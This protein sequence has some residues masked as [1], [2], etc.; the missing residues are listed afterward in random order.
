MSNNEFF[1]TEITL[2]KHQREWVLKVY[3]LMCQLDTGPVPNM[4]GEPERKTAVRLIPQTDLGIGFDCHED[5]PHIVFRSPSDKYGYDKVNTY[6]LTRFIQAIYTEF[7]LDTCTVFSIPSI[8]EDHLGCVSYFITREGILEHSSHN[9]EMERYRDWLAKRTREIVH[10][11]FGRLRD[12]LTNFGSRLVRFK[13]PKCGNDEFSRAMLTHDYVEATGYVTNNGDFN[14]EE[15]GK[16]TCGETLYANN[17]VRCE[18]CHA[19]YRTPSL[20]PL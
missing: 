10:R 1:Y 6:A 13:C 17:I 16:E 5:G 20:Q 12:Q 9:W 11:D 18:G 4:P 19:E 3:E 2:E 15:Y 7:D 14:A 8:D